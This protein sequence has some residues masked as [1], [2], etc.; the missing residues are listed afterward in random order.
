MSASLKMLQICR[1]CLKC[2]SSANSLTNGFKITFPTRS[3]FSTTNL[4]SRKKPNDPHQGES[5]DDPLD[6]TL[7]SAAEDLSNKISGEKGRHVATDLIQKLKMMKMT[8]PEREDTNGQQNLG[9]ILSKMTTDQVKHRGEGRSKRRG[10]RD[11][12][13]DNRKEVQ[14]LSGMFDDMSAVRYQDSEN[15]DYHAMKKPNP[16]GVER[17]YPDRKSSDQ[18]GPRKWTRQPGADRD[19]KLFEGDR[20]GI[21]SPEDIKTEVK[22]EKETLWDVLEKEELTKLQTAAPKNGFEE[23]IVWTKQG[24]LWHFPIDNEQGWE[25]EQ[26]TGFHEH[27]FLE[28]L[29]EDFPKKGPLRQFMNHVVVAL[30]KNAFITA[31]QKREHIQ[32]FREYF[33]ENQ[34]ILQESL[35]ENGLI[36]NETLSQLEA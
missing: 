32:W 29:T 12:K 16:Q 34:D 36:R 21:F 7:Q 28:H 18:R 4:L 2:R 22:K 10:Q 24:K 23:M 1:S 17:K 25:L 19:F 20:L 27:I 9:S 15:Y 11:D 3:I 35:G 13:R 33:I 31:E 26:K 6:K 5:E 30:S 14:A 8:K